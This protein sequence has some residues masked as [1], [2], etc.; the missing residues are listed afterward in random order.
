MILSGLVI[1]VAHGHHCQYL[2]VGIVV[3]GV[4]VSIFATSSSL[5]KFCMPGRICSPYLHAVMP[6]AHDQHG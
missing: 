3:I 4:I 5:G 2:A 1:N 6:V